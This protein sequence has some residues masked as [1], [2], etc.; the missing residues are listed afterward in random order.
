MGGTLARTARTFGASVETTVN[1]GLHAVVVGHETDDSDENIQTC[2]TLGIPLVHRCWL[3]FCFS[4]FA[5]Q[6][7]EPFLWQW[8]APNSWW[9][10]YHHWRLD[11]TGGEGPV[12]CP[13]EPDAQVGQHLDESRMRRLKAL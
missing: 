11:S 6:D 8:P 10:A 2:Q 13:S 4:T 1:A 9:D 3:S 12:R 5:L 7:P